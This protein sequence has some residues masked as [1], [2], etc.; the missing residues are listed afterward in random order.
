M[1]FADRLPECGE[2]MVARATAR[3][4]KWLFA[5]LWEAAEQGVFAPN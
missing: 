5:Q 4:E 3:Q 1:P 2:L